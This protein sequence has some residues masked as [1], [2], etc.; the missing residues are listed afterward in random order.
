MDARCIVRNGQR[1]ATNRWRIARNAQRIARRG[2]DVPGNGQR[3]ATNGW[4]IA[5]NGRCTARNGQSFFTR[6]YR[7]SRYAERCPTNWRESPRPSWSID[8]WFASHL[9]DCV[10]HLYKDVGVLQQE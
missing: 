9:S 5:R 6:A 3:I 7:R 8:G 4:S 10:A 1:I 2:R